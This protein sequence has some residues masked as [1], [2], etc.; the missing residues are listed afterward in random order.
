ML[1]LPKTLE[2]E[3]GGLMSLDITQARLA[4][5]AE[6]RLLD[7]DE[8][9]A[10]LNRA[11]Q[12][13]VDALVELHADLDERTTKLEGLLTYDERVLSQLKRLKLR[14]K[15]MIEKRGGNTQ[16]EARLMAAA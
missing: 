15:E 1:L 3:E 16:S 2:R 11:Q 4:D 5:R 8:G 9:I 12:L 6:T 7:V 13:S 14:L 10:W